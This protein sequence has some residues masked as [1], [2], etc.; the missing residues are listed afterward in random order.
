VASG[1]LKAD[2]ERADRGLAPGGA[3]GHR[4]YLSVRLLSQRAGILVAQVTT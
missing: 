3:E 1:F 2:E 4:N